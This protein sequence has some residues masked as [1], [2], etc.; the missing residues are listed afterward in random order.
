MAKSS[1]YS[2]KNVAVTIDGQNVLGVWD[3][4]DAVVIAPLEDIG[5]ML[6]GADGSSL[7]SQSANEGA[8]ITIRLQHTSPAHRLLHQKWARQRARGIR[9]TGFPVT[10]IDVDSNEGGS[11]DQAFIRSA[12]SD[13]KGKNAG[14]REWVLVTGQWRP[15]VPRL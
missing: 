15:E 2:M 12:P 10:I 5:T 8:T 3:G 13:A 7:F 4:D 9:V 11:T 6:V 14:A 1:A